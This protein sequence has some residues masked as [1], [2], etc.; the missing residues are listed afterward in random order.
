M[1]VII[2][3]I[4]VLILLSPDKEEATT[5]VIAFGIEALITVALFGVNPILGI[6]V[7]YLFLRSWG[8]Q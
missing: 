1:A 6:I 5:N 7:G 8:K 3:I 2:I 4:F